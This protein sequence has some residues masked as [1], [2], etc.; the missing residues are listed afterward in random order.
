[1]YKDA[2]LGNPDPFIYILVPQV[3]KQNAAFQK[4]LGGLPGGDNAMIAC[5]FV[6]EMDDGEEVYIMHASGKQH[7]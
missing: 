1:L 4:R 2:E 6:T 7:G 5:G 3:K